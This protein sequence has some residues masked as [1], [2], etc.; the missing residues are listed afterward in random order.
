MQILSTSCEIRS[1]DRLQQ[2]GALCG[3]GD[4]RRG[5]G[6]NRHADVTDRATSAAG[7][8]V[9]DWTLP[10][11]AATLPG[12]DGKESHEKSVQAFRFL[13][14][15]EVTERDRFLEELCELQ[16]PALDEAI[17]VVEE[18][19]GRPLPEELKALLRRSDGMFCRDLIRIYATNELSERNE[20]NEVDQYVPGWLMIGD[21][22]GD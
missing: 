6:R 3:G 2:L 18:E 13:G 21:D 22:S 16:S 4:F 12:K 20:T 14:C 1:F 19:L 17:A 5:F 15:L 8:L 11:A 10:L 7:A 9:L